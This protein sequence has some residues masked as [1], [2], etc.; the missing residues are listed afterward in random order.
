MVILNGFYPFLNKFIKG[1]GVGRQI[2]KNNRT[3]AIGF[4]Y[5]AGQ[6]GEFFF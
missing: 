5:I 4:G 6:K 2:F 1:F 3:F